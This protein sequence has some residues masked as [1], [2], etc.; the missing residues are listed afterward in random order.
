MLRRRKLVGWLVGLGLALP[1]AEALATPVYNTDVS[2]V[3]FIGSRSIAGGGLVKGG[4]SF[5]SATLSWAITSNQDNSLHYS[6]SIITNSQQGVSHF[7]F[8]LSDNCT[9]VGSCFQNIAVTGGTLGSIVFETDTSHNG[10]PGMPTGSSIIGAKVNIASG[11]GSFTLGFDSVRAPVWA[12]FYTKGG[13][14]TSNGFSLFNKGLGLEGTDSNLGDFVAMPDTHDCAPDVC[15][16]PPCTDCGGGGGGGPPPVPEPTSI[17]L[18]GA[19]LFGML[20]GKRRRKNG[21]A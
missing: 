9:A 10:N 21:R 20:L 6:Y 2:A 1:A 8:D 5:T 13:N 12:D 14:G 7:V 11:L 16:P 19:G 4:G 3:D 15:G 18:L 17:A